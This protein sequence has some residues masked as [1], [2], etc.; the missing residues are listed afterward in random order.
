MLWGGRKRI[1][2]QEA[3]KSGKKRY[4]KNERSTVSRKVLKQR[5]GKSL[6]ALLRW[7][8]RVVNNGE[9]Y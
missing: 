1:K 4:G 7:G 5:A 8:G 6:E 9:S 2:G 3:N